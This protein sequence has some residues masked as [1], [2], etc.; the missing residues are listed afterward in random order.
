MTYR[1]GPAN[2][3][4]ARTTNPASTAT[5]CCTR[6]LWGWSPPVLPAD[7]TTKRRVDR[8]LPRTGLPAVLYF[9]AVIALLMVA[10][11]LPVR[12]ELA[13]DGLAALVG[14][15]WCGVNFWRCR[16]A[17]CL[18]TSAGWLGLSGF[19]FVEAGLGRSLIHGYEQPVFLAVLGAGI[20][21]EVAWYLLRGTNA[22]T[23]RD[24]DLPS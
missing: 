24:R 12:A 15:G 22:L 16:H 3:A 7:T 17:H 4:N 5:D 1:P 8:V 21:F 14:G 18:V 9:G 6:G 20:V 13:V 19:A 11:H 23:R 10:P 2:L